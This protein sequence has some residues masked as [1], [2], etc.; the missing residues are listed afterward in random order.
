MK[1]TSK[2]ITYLIVIGFILAISLGFVSENMCGSYQCED[3]LDSIAVPLG[4]FT[5][6]IFPIAIILLFRPKPIFNSWWRFAKIYLPIALT[7]ILIM[8]FSSDDG[9]WGVGADF[10]AEITI[11]LTASLF[12]II[13]LILII[14]KSIKLRKK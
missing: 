4:F 14:Y 1:I 7:L 8:G 3:I 11:W 12:L 5:I 6:A 13:S 9:S 10:D 2:N